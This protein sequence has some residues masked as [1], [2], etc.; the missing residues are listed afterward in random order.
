MLNQG[1]HD[2]SREFFERVVS[3]KPEDATART[4]LAAA[5]LAL[6]E[7]EEAVEELKKA[8]EL[9]PE[10]QSAA[11]MGETKEMNVHLRIDDMET[12]KSIMGQ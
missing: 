10:S 9:D 4:N 8:I 12:W 1:D 11:T 2:S 3:I 5:Q 7:N 6:G